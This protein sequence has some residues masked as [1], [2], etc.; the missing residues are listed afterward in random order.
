MQSDLNRR[1]FLRT[2]AGVTAG[3]AREAWAAIAAR[4][5]NIYRADITVGEARHLRG[6]W[7]AHAPS[8]RPLVDRK[9]APQ[10]DV[11]RRAPFSSP[12]ARWRWD[13]SPRRPT[14]P[15]GCTIAA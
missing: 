4:G 15:S 3:V 10:P 13:S 14:P 5:W 9:D 7:A 1:Q 11:M 8:Q 6:H 2:A 12:G